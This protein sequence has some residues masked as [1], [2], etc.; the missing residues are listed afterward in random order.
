MSQPE[1]EDEWRPCQ[2]APC[3]GRMYPDLD[4]DLVV[5]GCAACGNEAYEYRKAAGDTCQAGVPAALQQR[6]PLAG[7]VFLGPSISR[8]PG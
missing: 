8:R 6:E 2:Y 5:W 1:I 4:G 7:T 3:E